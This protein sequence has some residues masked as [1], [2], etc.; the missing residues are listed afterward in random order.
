M[1]VRDYAGPALPADEITLTAPADERLSSRIYAYPQEM[2]CALRRYCDWF[3]G[4]AP[5]TLHASAAD[6]L[7]IARVQPIGA[8]ATD[9][10]WRKTTD[11]LYDTLY[12]QIRA[13][14]SVS[15]NRSAATPAGGF[16]VFYSACHRALAD[17]GVRVITESLLPPRA[18]LQAAPAE[19]ITVWAANPTPL[20]AAAGLKPPSAPMKTISSYVLDVRWS[21]HTPFQVRNFTATGSIFRLHLYRAAC[22]VRLT[23]ECVAPADEAELRQE[24]RRLMEG[25]G[26]E[27]L[28]LGALVAVDMAPRWQWWTVETVRAV[29]NL[30]HWAERRLGDAFVPAGWLTQGQPARLRA[31]SRGLVQAAEGAPMLAT[32]T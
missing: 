25:F 24:I 15:L 21:G 27:Q 1:F 23:A 29:E 28:S 2:G 30:A 18:A 20:F 32:G 12:G 22:G 13:D 17:Q 6:S 19:Q 9:L 4:V 3:L 10:A 8:D 7:G 5:E 26:G 31:I 11:P 16:D 14:W